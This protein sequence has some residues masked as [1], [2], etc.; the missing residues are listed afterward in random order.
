MREQ[1][2][3]LEDYELDAREIGSRIHAVLQDVYREL[4]GP[5][6]SFPRD[7]PERLLSRALALARR[8]WSRHTRDIAARTRV[9]YPLLWEST[10]EIWGRALERF[11]ERD[12]EDVRR[13]DA[14]VL[15]LEREESARLT[16]GGG[17]TLQVLGRFDRIATSREGLVVTDYKT[18]GA[19]RHHVSLSR[20]LK[21]T[22]LQLPVYLLLAR[23]LAGAGTLP[24]P[25]ARGEVLGV[26]PIFSEEDAIARLE[27]T[28]LDDVQDG[29]LETLRVLLELLAS[30]S[31][32][33]NDTSVR[34]AS[35]P[36]RRACRRS[37]LPTVN[38]VTRARNGERYAMLRRKNRHAPTLEQAR[39]SA[40]KEEES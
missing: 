1:D 5:E 38:R 20:I 4:T 32:P 3:V 29:L 14:R 26:G 13:V 23:A 35:C 8:A 17:V 18:S 30:G 7:E 6:G 25:P 10:E 2:E 21:G 11:L 33:L 36:Y 28:D 40:R 19:I 22:R 16:L 39:Q 37:H 27:T 12:L 34:C 31:F 15:G 24:A 9:S